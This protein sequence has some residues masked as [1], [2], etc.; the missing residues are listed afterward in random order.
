MNKEKEGH[1]KIL[2][3]DFEHLRDALTT[4]YSDIDV[5]K[6]KNL[7]VVESLKAPVTAYSDATT[8]HQENRFWAVAV[9]IHGEMLET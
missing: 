3:K 4:T 8:S 6:L 1:T 2:A 9:L 7:G 5:I